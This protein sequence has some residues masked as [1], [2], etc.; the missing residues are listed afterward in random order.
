MELR[1]LRYFTAVAEELHFG[2]AA[3]RL[4]LAPPSLSQQ[5]RVLERSLGTELF[6]RSPRAVRL[7]AAGEALL[8]R[9]RVLLAD[10]DA[11]VAEV[12]AVAAGSSGHLRIG[13]FTSNAGEL[14]LPILRQFQTLHPSVSLSFQ[15]VGFAGQIDALVAR[16]VDVAFVRPPIASPEVEVSTLATEERMALVPTASSLADAPEL[17]LEDLDELPFIEGEALPMPG[18]W[19]DFWILRES[20]GGKDAFTRPARQPLATYA[21]VVMEVAMNGTM[22]T[23]PA[24]VGTLTHNPGVTLVPVRGLECDVAVAVRSSAGTGLAQDFVEVAVDVAARTRR[25]ASPTGQ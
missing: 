18:D 7:T 17:R 19:T 24:S 23:V 13:L 20:R 14:T 3:T 16:E 25:E 10:A 6:E 11:T 4:H 8:E 21:E 12:R 22:T 9:A 1:Q 2:R 15:E 5:I